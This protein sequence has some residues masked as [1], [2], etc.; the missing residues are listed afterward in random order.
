LASGP[1]PPPTG[2]APF[3]LQVLD[4]STRGAADA[5][6]VAG[7]LATAQRVPRQGA[8]G[9]GRL[10]YSHTHS[11]RTRTWLKVC[12][13]ERLHAMP[14]G[15]R[16][17]GHGAHGCGR[18]APAPTTT[19]NS[20]PTARRPGSQQHE[21]R[22][23]TPVGGAPPVTRPRPRRAWVRPAGARATRSCAKVHG[24]E[25]GFTSQDTQ[26]P[27]A[28]HL[29]ARYGEKGKLDPRAGGASRARRGARRR[30]TRRRDTGCSPSPTCK[31]SKNPTET[32]TAPGAS[33]LG[34]ATTPGC[35]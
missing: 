23:K 27:A 20:P 21:T 5:R 35:R 17:H 13:A 14:T 24:S 6:R 34:V 18:P 7:A 3:A 19:C 28:A 8:L 32:A 31:N 10:G 22:R 16:G 15:R 26:A 12:G 29:A 25:A 4:E 33:R 1:F 30:G 9:C 11:C 2:A